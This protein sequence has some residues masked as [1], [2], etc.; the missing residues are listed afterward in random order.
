MESFKSSKCIGSLIHTGFYDKLV[1]IGFPYDEGAKTAVLRQGASYGPDCFRRFLH[2]V[3]PVKNAEY[4]IDLSA[5]SMCDYGNISAA[6][7]AACY[8]KLSAKLRLTMGRGQTTFVVGGTRDLVPYCAEAVLEY[9]KDVKKD[10]KEGKDAAPD[11][12]EIKPQQEV[13]ESEPEPPKEEKKMLESH[14]ILFISVSPI[15]ETE[16]NVQLQDPKMIWRRVLENPAFSKLGSKIV[17][18][19]TSS[20]CD[21]EN[22]DYF[23]EKGGSVVW[24]QDVRGSKI[25]GDAKHVAQTQAGLFFEELLGKSAEEYENVYVSFNLESILVRNSR[26]I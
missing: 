22:Y 10:I 3:G 15:I 26:V 21:K 11:F 13:K 4:G 17:A 9:S 2:K 8:E 1:L 5:L 19:G 23:T 6:S 12:P 20:T 25:T 24:L 7:I 16:P 14:K 18:F